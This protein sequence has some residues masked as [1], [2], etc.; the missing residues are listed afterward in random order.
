MLEG[1]SALEIFFDSLVTWLHLIDRGEFERNF[2]EI[3]PPE[4]GIK[5]RKSW[6]SRSIICRPSEH[7]KGLEICTKHFDK[8]GNFTF[9]S[10]CIPYL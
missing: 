3:F 5:E 9:A 8:T 6:F 1:L 7:Y 2:L 4:T 10:V